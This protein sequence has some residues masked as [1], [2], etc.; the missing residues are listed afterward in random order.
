MNNQTSCRVCHSPFFSEPLL[1][2]KDMPCAAQNFPDTTT[3][4]SDHG[5]DLE[6]SQCQGCGLI[7]LGNPPVEYHRD[8]IRASAFSEEMQGFRRDQ[9]H[10]F[11]TDY[12]LLNEKVIEIGCGKGEYLSLLVESGTDAF[13]IEHLAESVE[14]CQ[15]SNLKVVE[16]YLPETNTPLEAGPFKAFFIMNFFEHLPDPNAMLKAMTANLTEDGIGLIEVP[17]FDMI[18]QQNLFSEFI[19]DHLFYFT[20]DTL[21]STLNY[22]GFE[23]I[24]CK[25]IWHDYILSTVVRRK[26]PKDLT[27]LTTF[28]NKIGNEIHQFLDEQQGKKV[29]IWGA[30]HQALAVISLA[31]ISTRI[32]VV[33]D[34]APF[35]QNKFTPATHIPIVSPDELDKGEL[36]VVIIMA[37][38][39]SDEVHRTIKERWGTGVSVAILRNYGLEVIGD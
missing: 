24:E 5:Q 20:E 2:L 29:A 38:S 22:N 32:E 34:S 12:G 23:I 31:K 4:A 37:A 28:Q 33:L 15:A 7:Q 1:L 16:G 18:L 11:V 26:Q 39:Y 36:E 35:K 10:Q 14:F 17:N 25:S 8:V 19:N 6:L 21:R 9:F 30:G 27:Y 13:G 3:I